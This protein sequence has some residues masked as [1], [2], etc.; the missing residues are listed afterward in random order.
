MR[1]VMMMM[2]VDITL[3]TMF[4]TSSREDVVH[5]YHETTLQIILIIDVVV[6]DDLTL[7]THFYLRDPPSPAKG[8][9]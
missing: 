8:Q 3:L 2:M 9:G 5:D 6:A 4:D 7:I 1:M